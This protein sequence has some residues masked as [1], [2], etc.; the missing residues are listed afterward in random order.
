M[1]TPRA[2]DINGP[3]HVGSLSPDEKPL[4]EIEILLVCNSSAPA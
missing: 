1:S 2:G 4:F 3:E